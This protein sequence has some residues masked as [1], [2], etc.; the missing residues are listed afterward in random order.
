MAGNPFIGTGFESFWLGSRANRMW[1]MYYFHP[2]QA[3][4]GYLEVYLELGWIG[5]FLLAAIIFAGYRNALALLR[6]NPEAGR[7]RMTF[8]AV[9]LVY[10]VTEAGFRMMTL[11]W[12]FLLLSATVVPSLALETASEALP[13]DAA[14]NFETW[15]Q[16]RQP[17]S[18]FARR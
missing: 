7:I 2:T 10:N 16:P 18:D 17:V 11:T 3:H 6:T 1:A 12:I 14:P 9:A 8:I 15:H 13:E 4:N 5:I